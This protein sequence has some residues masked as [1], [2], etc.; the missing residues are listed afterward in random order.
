MGPVAQL[1]LWKI[2]LGGRAFEPRLWKEDATTSKKRRAMNCVLCVGHSD[3]VCK[4]R[5]SVGECWIYTA[6]LRP[7]SGLHAGIVFQHL[8]KCRATAILKISSSGNPVSITARTSSRLPLNLRISS[9]TTVSKF[10]TGNLSQSW[11]LVGHSVTNALKRLTREIKRCLV[12]SDNP[13]RGRRD[14]RLR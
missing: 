2:L 14:I 7:R 1:A 4:D 9:A 10:L 11:Y 13:V 3:D 6:A 8:P 5:R 12:R